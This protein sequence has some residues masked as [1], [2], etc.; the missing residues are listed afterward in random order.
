MHENMRR[1]SESRSAVSSFIQEQVVFITGPK[2]G[3]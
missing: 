1:F 3:P 2:T